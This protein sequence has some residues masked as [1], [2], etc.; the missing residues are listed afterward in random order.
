MLLLQ[1]LAQLCGRVHETC[2]RVAE[3]GPE[4]GGLG[5]WVRLGVVGC[6]WVLLGVVGCG[7]VWL[8][9]VGCYLAVV[10]KTVL[11]FHFGW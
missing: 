3:A 4:V 10:V 7:W 5:G 11:G 1:M 8:G 6:G 9:V 2:F